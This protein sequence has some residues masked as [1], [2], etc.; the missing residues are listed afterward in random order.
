M[1]CES[2]SLGRKITCLITIQIEQTGYAASTVWCSITHPPTPAATPTLTQVHP[3]CRTKPTGSAAHLA[4][5]ITPTTATNTTPTTPIHHPHYCNH[6]H[7]DWTAPPNL[8]IHPYTRQWRDKGGEWHHQIKL[9]QMFYSFLSCLGVFVQDTNKL[10]IGSA[11][12]IPSY[13]RWMGGCHSR[14]TC[15]KAPVLLE[16]TIATFSE[17]LFMEHWTKHV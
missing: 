11:L 4:T 3:P 15:V 7:C 14:S 9:L 17:L 2:A 12:P 10:N 1:R 16:I 6:S 5:T 13:Y 8:Y